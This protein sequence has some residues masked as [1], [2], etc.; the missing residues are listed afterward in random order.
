MFMIAF[1]VIFPLFANATECLIGLA[2]IL[3][4]IPVYIVMVLWEGKPKSFKRLYS[5]YHCSFLRFSL[6]VW[7][8]LVMCLWCLFVTFLMSLLFLL[9]VCVVSCFSS[10]PIQ[11]HDLGMLTPVFCK[12]YFGC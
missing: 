3:T 6:V 1:L 11:M 4:G 8:L 7:P 12:P 10:G 5:L 9:V 2:M